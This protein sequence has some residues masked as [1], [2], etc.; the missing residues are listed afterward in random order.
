MARKGE[1]DY[2]LVNVV[3][4]N[5]PKVYA[6]KW[7]S[8]YL[9]KNGYK[10]A[11]LEPGDTVVVRTKDGLQLVEVASVLGR[12]NETRSTMEKATNWIVDVVETTAWTAKVTEEREK[13][14]AAA[15]AA[16]LLDELI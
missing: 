11:R 4:P 7:S 16:A 8:A 14:Q 1:F 9:H 12:D 5:S 3:F 2:D 13:A 10:A 6:Y 15:E